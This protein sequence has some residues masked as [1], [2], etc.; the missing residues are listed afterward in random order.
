MMK[1]EPDPLPN[2]Y[3]EAGGKAL[4]QVAQKQGQKMFDCMQFYSMMKKP[5]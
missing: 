1:H 5:S 2:H 3:D 4:T